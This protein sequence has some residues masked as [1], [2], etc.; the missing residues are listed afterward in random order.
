MMSIF[1]NTDRSTGDYHYITIIKAG[2]EVTTNK[3][4]FFI[5]SFYTSFFSTS[6]AGHVTDVKQLGLWMTS[7]PRNNNTLKADTDRE[8]LG[9]ADTILWRPR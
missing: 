2:Y 5:S 3:I 8:R 4:I 7:N 6:F 1:F 9:Y